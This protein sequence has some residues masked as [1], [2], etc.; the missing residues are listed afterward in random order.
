[1]Y[2]LVPGGIWWPTIFPALAIATLVIAINLIADSVE[3]HTRVMVSHRRP[4][5]LDAHTGVGSWRSS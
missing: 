3:A 5:S 4:F 1:M 2:N